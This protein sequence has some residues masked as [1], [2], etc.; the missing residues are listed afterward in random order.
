MYTWQC[1]YCRG[2]EYS[3]ANHQEKKEITCIYCGKRYPNVFFK[4]KNNKLNG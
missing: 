4:E 3:A 1:L 2:K